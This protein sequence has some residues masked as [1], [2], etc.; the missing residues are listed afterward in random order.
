MKTFANLFILTAT[1]L[2]GGTE[3]KLG[4]ASLHQENEAFPVG[5]YTWGTDV[6]DSTDTDFLRFVKSPDVQ[7]ETSTGDV[8]F[9]V[10]ADASSGQI[11]EK[12][13]IIPFMQA[14]RL[15]TKGVLWMTYGDFGSHNEKGMLDFIDALFDL[16][17]AQPQ[18]T[19]KNLAPLGVSLDIEN[20]GMQP[21]VISGLQKLRKYVD[22][23]LAFMPKGGFLIQQA[24]GGYPDSGTT[25]YTMDLADSALY[26]VYRSYMTDKSGMG[27]H[28]DNNLLGRMKW[29]M[30]LQCI[31]CLDPNYKPRAKISILVEGACYV[32]EYCGL[33]SFCGQMDGGVDNLKETFA[34]FDRQLHAVDWAPPGRFEELLARPERRYGI[35]DWNWARCLYPPSISKGYPHCNQGTLKY[36]VGLC[37]ALKKTPQVG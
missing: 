29:F 15:D 14:I 17:K 20:E 6:F 31:N 4:N 19:L 32:G 3:G 13:N 26:L 11:F 30:Q 35:H 21:M 36:G 37:Q 12:D 5:F 2:I 16:L 27:L 34:E 8:W 22:E 28:E 24:V 23:D 33:I 9:G 7:K 10:G 1:L 18:D 25:S